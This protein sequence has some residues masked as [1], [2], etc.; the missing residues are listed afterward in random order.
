MNVNAPLALRYQAYASRFGIKF[1]PR[2]EQEGIDAA[3]ST[4]QGNV[5]HEIPAIQAVYAID[6]PSG[7]SNHTLAFAQVDL[8]TMPKLTFHRQ[9]S[10]FVLM[11][12]P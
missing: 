6:V 10:A 4:D 11:K 8:L 2:L 1:P 12:R 5:S 3:A 9:L 7:E